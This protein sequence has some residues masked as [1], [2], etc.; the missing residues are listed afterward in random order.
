[1]CNEYKLTPA[2]EVLASQ[3]GQVRPIRETFNHDL[4]LFQVGR[5]SAGTNRPWRIVSGVLTVLLV[6]SGLGQVGPKDSPGP[7]PP[8]YAIDHPAVQS[9]YTTTVQREEPV[10]VGSYVYLTLREGVIEQGMD[11]LP[12][13]SGMKGRVLP[14]SR[15]E[16]MNGML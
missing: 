7:P 3:L 2:Q 10:S 9:A 15:K 12:A 4:L 16:W 14:K 11:A 5:A 13:Q 6:C 8:G 1:M